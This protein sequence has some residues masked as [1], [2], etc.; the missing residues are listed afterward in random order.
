MC[1]LKSGKNYFLPARQLECLF[2]LINLNELSERPSASVNSHPPSNKA[3]KFLRKLSY[4]SYL[5]YAGRVLVSPSSS[6]QK[7]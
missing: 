1:L 3:P 6:R 5:D 2:I 7:V 4:R